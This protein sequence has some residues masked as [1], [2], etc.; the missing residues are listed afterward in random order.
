MNKKVILLPFLLIFLFLEVGCHKPQ[1]VLPEHI[2][3]IAVPIFKNNTRKYGIEA[4]ITQAIIKEMTQSGQVAVVAQGQ[5]DAL[6]SGRV[7]DYHVIPVSF[8]KRDFV[9]Q[10]QLT[11]TIDFAFKDLRRDQVLWQETNFRS[12]AYYVLRKTYS[13]TEAEERQAFEDILRD[14]SERVVSRIYYGF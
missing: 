10:Y 8:D 6:L 2:K 3:S 1:M 7:M 12:D 5:A 14:L 9:T 4:E 11:V 13:F